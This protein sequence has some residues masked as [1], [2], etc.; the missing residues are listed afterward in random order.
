MIQTTHEIMDYKYEVHPE[1][2]YIEISP[3]LYFIAGGNG[4][5]KFSQGIIVNNPAKHVHQPSSFSKFGKK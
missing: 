4:L 5:E 2:K 1:V 3:S